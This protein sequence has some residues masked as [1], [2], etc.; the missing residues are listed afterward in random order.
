MGHVQ[1]HAA[2]R[3]AV[4]RY[5]VWMKSYVEAIKTYNNALLVE[6]IDLDIWILLKSL[7]KDFT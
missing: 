5:I 3:Q 1:R 6:L 2:N 4:E 7:Q